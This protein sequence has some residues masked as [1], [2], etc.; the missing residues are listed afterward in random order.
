MSSIRV[1]VVEDSAF[2]R[3]VLRESLQK[4][5]GI[6]VVGFA[7][8]GLDALEKI[9]ELHPDVITVDLVMPN[10]DG[11]GLLRALRSTPKPP[12]CIVVS[13]A[14]SESDQVLTAL[15][16]GAVDFIHKPTALA[17]DRLYEISRELA[18]KV[19]TA[20]V[21]VVRGQSELGRVALAPRAPSKGEVGLVVVGTSTGG[22]QALKTLLSMLPADFPAA[23]A[24]ALHIPPGY[25]E[26]LARRLD[27]QSALEV[28]EAEEG[29]A[30]FPGR[31]VL[32]RA[33][34]HLKVEARATACIARLSMDEGQH[35]HR[36]SVDVLFQSAAEA[37]GSRVLGVVLTGMGNDGL[38][39]AR[40][41]K[42]R[43]G[44]IVSEAA[45]SCI[46]YGMPRC[47]FE[48]GLSD[49][50]IPLEELAAALC[51][52]VAVAPGVTSG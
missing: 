1:L 22:P 29:M 31:A 49:A 23:I 37:V 52:Q 28:L 43:G 39:G 21:A 10:L 16:L 13:M 5:P 17:T 41:I 32:A 45:S 34:H 35:A 46:I 11:L 20:A 25:T 12:R 19:R 30:L 36:P 27:Q 44:R 3:K 14:E 4:E 6:E 42:E 8:D 50:V 47:V 15:E 33:G 2:A 24:I 18:Q 9:A 7:Q 38:A 40:K 48:E 51:G 26:T